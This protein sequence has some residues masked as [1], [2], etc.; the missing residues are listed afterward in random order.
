[1]GQ[2]IDTVIVSN[3]GPVSFVKTESG[4]ET[5]RGAGGLAGALDPV[6]RELGDRGA[7][8][9]AATSS[10]DR[11][12]I[13]AGAT[14]GLSDQLGYAVHL[15][16]ID[17]ARYAQYYDVVSN[18]MLWFANHCLWEELGID[19]FGP[20]EVAAFDDAYEP[21]NQQFADA[22][23]DV[24]DPSS[25]VLLQDYHLATVAGHLR[26]ERPDQ[27]IF[28]FTHSSF[29]GKNG[30]GRLP[31]PIPRKVIEGMLGAD[32]LGFHVAAWVEGFLEC[33][34]AIGATVA[35]DD[36]AIDHD[37][38]RTWVR[39]YPIPVDADELLERAS[40]PAAQSW[41]ITLLGAA[42]GPL[43]VRADR[44]EPSKNIVRG[45]E[46]WG[47]LLD[48]RP[49]LATSARFIA[50]LYPSRQSMPEYRNET[51]DIKAVVD[52]VNER[53]PGSIQLYL[54]DDFDRTLGALMVYDVLLV[55]PLMD[56]MNLVSKEGP[57]VN[58]E[59]GV[60]VL[61]T[62]AG[63]FEEMGEAA[64]AIDD[65]RDVEQT[66][67][68]LETALDLPDAER[69]RRADSLRALARGKKPSDWINAQIDDLKEIRKGNPPRSQPLLPRQ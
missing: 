49:D 39:E 17:P 59:D 66:A 8:I 44:T 3:R 19:S 29:C 41:A 11:E 54:Q 33:C 7:W 47:S 25:L 1:M 18:R 10:D 37:G 36:W 69:R 23:R 24:T 68:A 30:L 64:I 61:S 50:C 32:L 52:R 5:R 55:N 12:A 63:S 27:T 43:V 62:G 38:R 26:K 56:G 46:A 16:D 60:L 40:G 65:A 22:I 14:K 48:R 6:A 58:R 53:H 20:R 57:V 28:H 15:L 2:G 67:R 9:A 51:E 45:F 42:R 31:R 13:A 4:F 34:D 21:V 35:E